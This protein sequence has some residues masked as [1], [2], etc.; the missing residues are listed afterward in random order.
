MDTAHT[1]TSTLAGAELDEHGPALL[2]VWDAKHPAGDHAEDRHLLIEVFAIAASQN[3]AHHQ[4]A[5]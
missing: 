5:A 1:T 4:H 3:V 2:A